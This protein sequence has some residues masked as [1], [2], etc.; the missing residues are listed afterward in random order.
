MKMYTNS[1]FTR[2]SKTRGSPGV[3]FNRDLR[4]LPGPRARTAQAPGFS[5]EASNLGLCEASLLQT[6][7]GQSPHQQGPVFTSAL[8]I[9]YGR[10]EEEPTFHLSPVP[11]AA[12]AVISKRLLIFHKLSAM[13]PSRFLIT[14]NI[15][16]IKK[17]PN[18]TDSSRG[19]MFFNVSS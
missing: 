11:I 18:T 9:L 19:E 1:R 2:S 7:F 14:F 6:L 13:L 3:Q 17:R 5:R 12:S 4:L 16:E 10:A 8:Q 15:Y